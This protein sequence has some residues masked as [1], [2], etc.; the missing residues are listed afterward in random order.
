MTVIIFGE[1]L[2]RPITP[3]IFAGNIQG[4]DFFK[5]TQSTSFNEFERV[6]PEKNSRWI[7]IIGSQSIGEPPMSIK[8]GRPKI[9]P[10]KP[11]PVRTNPIQVKIKAINTNSRDVKVI[12]FLGSY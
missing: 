5:Y 8:I 4:R 7:P 11:R 2:I 9:A 10:P 1:R 12:P 3:I 6:M